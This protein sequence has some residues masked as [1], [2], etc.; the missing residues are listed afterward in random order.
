ML[1]RTVFAV[2]TMMHMLHRTVFAVQTI[3]QHVTYSLNIHQSPEHC[4][5]LS[6]QR[7]VVKL[8]MSLAAT[9]FFDF[10]VVFT[11][12]RTYID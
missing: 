8:F 7:I 1:H 11:I 10:F 12:N 3:K 6:G 2:Q 9:E 4:G 5:A